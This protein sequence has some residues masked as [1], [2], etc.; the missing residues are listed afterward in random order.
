M[1]KG[2]SMRYLKKSKLYSI[3]KEV[4][5]LCDFPMLKDCKYICYRG[6]EWLKIYHDTYI[7][8]ICSMGCGAYLSVKVYYYD[9]FCNRITIS[10]S[11]LNGFGKQ[12]IAVV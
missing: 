8:E 3:A 11:V 2:D 7:Y 9:D 5:E 1:D 12:G 10:R 6:T 4:F